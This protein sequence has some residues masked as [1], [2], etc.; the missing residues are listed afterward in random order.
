MTMR[1]IELGLA[2]LID[3]PMN[4]LLKQKKNEKLIWSC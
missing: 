1:P 3:E 4:G 2:I